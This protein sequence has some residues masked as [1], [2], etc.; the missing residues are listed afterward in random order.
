M[1]FFERQDR[2]RRRTAVLVLGF[3]VAVTGVVAAVNLVAWI[4]L[5]MLTMEPQASL[6]EWVASPAAAWVSAI[7]VAAIAI[8][9]TV[10]WA[11][12]AHGGGGRVAILMGGSIVDPETD[13]AEARQLIN[14]VEEMAIAT[15]VPVPCVYLL[16]NE[17]GIN[18]FAAGL[19]PSNAAL[20]FSRGAIER[21]DRDELQ[22]V[23]AHEFSHIVNGDMR[24]NMRLLALLAGITVIGETGASFWRGMF[25]GGSRRRRGGVPI[26]VTSGRGSGGGRGGGGGGQGVL[27]L[28]AISLA[29]IIIGWL[30][31]FVGRVI[32]AGVSRQREF[33]ADAAA[34]QFTRN[35]DGIAGALLKI[36][37]ERRGSMLHARRAEEISH[38][39]FSRTVGGLTSLTA[40][41]PPIEERLKAIGPKYA[42]RYRQARKE[43]PPGDRE[44]SARQREATDPGGRGAGGPLDPVLDPLKPVLGPLEPATD[45]VAGG[46][47][48]A[49]RFA[50][51][52]AALAAL[53]GGPTDVHLD[54]ARGLLQRIPQPVRDALHH[55]RKASWTILALLA[56]EPAQR[57]TWPETEYSLIAGLREHLEQAFGAPEGELEATV[58]LPILELALPALQR[59]EPAARDAF[60]RH[61]D[62]LIRADGRLSVFEYT[63]RTLLVHHLRSESERPAGNRQLHDALDD[64]RI[65]LS[66]LSLAVSGPE[67]TRHAAFTAAIGP[68][69]PAGRALEPLAREDCTLRTFSGALERLDSLQP[70]AK[71]SLLMACADCVV[72]DGHIRPAEAELLRTIAAVLDTPVPPLSGG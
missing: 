64:V 38:M 8:G 43:S 25:L 37:Q 52:A 27:A 58:R 36:D 34:V 31:V 28:L 63:A 18:A 7:T 16:E 10:R 12:L 39:A 62:A 61:V 22:G 71:R 70:I 30:G 42:W 69:L 53:A 33:L 9:S 49:T 66:V 1:D 47:E 29:L 50:L 44:A 56:N 14:V 6:R 48:A 4:A 23:V 3:L 24:L 13:D 59:L 46:H 40:T 35:P 45:A 67:A 17:P 55:P 72:A 21:L 32:K 57:E 26:G 19:H 60:L 20:V 11:Q 41:H 54:M 2:A 15:G 5:P 51:S 65:V 68:L